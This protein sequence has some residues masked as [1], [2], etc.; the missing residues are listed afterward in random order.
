LSTLEHFLR[1]TVADRQSRCY[2]NHA[3]DQFLEHLIEIGVKR[4]IRIGG[5][6]KSVILEGKNLRVVSQGEAKTKSEGYVLGSTYSALEDQEKSTTST[7][8]LLHG[9]QKRP[10]WANLKNHLMSRH[11]RIGVQFSRFDKDGFEAVGPEPFDTWAK[12]IVPAHSRR[13]AATTPSPRAVDRILESAMQNVHS[14]PPHERH[15]LVE[16]WME[17]IRKDKTD[18]LYEQVE[19]AATLRQQLSNVHDEVDR[20][21]L[22]TADV[23]GVTTTGLAKR[24]SVLKRVQ[25]K[26][27]ICEE[28]G[29]VME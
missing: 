16:F 18:Q 26:V 12:A 7:L 22:Q 9:T 11:R 13:A 6:S 17:E 10:T 15:H 28:A 2:T 20:R 14:V 1:A 3:L 27:V 25:C 5:Q 24:I 21:V 4:V 8:G 29:E 19:H 23:I